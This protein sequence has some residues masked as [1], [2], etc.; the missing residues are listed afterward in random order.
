MPNNDTTI[1]LKMM[2]EFLISGF[3]DL[4]I[5]TI[6]AIQTMAAIA[7]KAMT[8]RIKFSKTSIPFSLYSEI[9]RLKTRFQVFRRPSNIAVANRLLRLPRIFQRY[10]AVKHRRIFAVVFAV[11]D[12]IADAFK[13]PTAFRR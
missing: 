13:L 9:G 7:N 8:I 4:T 12:E 11:G 5:A 2:A 1:K 6:L 3:L 10:R